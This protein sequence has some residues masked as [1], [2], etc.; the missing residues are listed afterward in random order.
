MVENEYREHPFLVER[1]WKEKRPDELLG[2]ICLSFGLPAGVRNNRWKEDDRDTNNGRCKYNH[3]CC[4]GDGPAHTDP[5][6]QRMRDRL[7]SQGK[8][9]LKPKPENVPVHAI[10]P[11][12]YK[13]M[14]KHSHAHHYK[15]PMPPFKGAGGARVCWGRDDALVEVN[16]GHG[17]GVFPHQQFRG[18]EGKLPFGQVLSLLALLVQKYKY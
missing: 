8:L 11:G 1:N 12:R 6:P 10:H 5:K 13:V 17:H 18:P 16:L 9:V 3:D 4:L 15:A 2:K 14:D 7:D